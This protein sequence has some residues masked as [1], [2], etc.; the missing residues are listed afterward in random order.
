MSLYDGNM[1]KITPIS[2][3]RGDASSFGGTMD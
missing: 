1:L 3:V 2:W